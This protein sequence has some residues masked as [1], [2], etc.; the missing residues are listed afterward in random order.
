MAPSTPAFLD[1]EV[2]GQKR[3]VKLA[4][5]CRVGRDRANDLVLDEES[6]SRNH[7][8][9][10]SSETGVYYINDLGSS[11]GTFVNGARISFPTPLKDG[12]KI[13]FGSFPIRF[14]H[15]QAP[16]PARMPAGA[17]ATS[18]LFAQ[19]LITVLVIDIRGFTVMAQRL[20]AATIAKITSALFREAGQVLQSRGAWGQKYIGDAV[21]AVWLHSDAIASELTNVLA[22]LAS[23]AK[24]A[25]GLQGQFGLEFPIRIGAGINSGL[26]SLGN[27]GSAAVPDYTALG[28]AVNRAFRL[29]SATKEVGLDVL[30]G[31]ETYDLIVPFEGV[32]RILQSKPVN[33]KGYAEPVPAWG[34]RFQD[35]LP[36][37]E[38]MEANASTSPKTG[39]PREA[40]TS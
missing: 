5:V 31:G 40:E 24:I 19:K 10:Y 36:A 38:A 22:A 11:N 34:A 15:E 20:D 35:L 32:R 26:G 37:V 13:V 30:I 1:A 39:R 14:R 12:D 21:M 25:A 6:V 2:K 29:E 3:E 16:A 7:A 4:E 33:L 28:D 17:A 23:L 27:V 8:L 18:V 9:V